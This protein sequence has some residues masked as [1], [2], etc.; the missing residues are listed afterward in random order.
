MFI[1]LI[2]IGDEILSGKR[3][4]KHLGHV[5]PMLAERGL[6]LSWCQIIGDDPNRITNT[7]KQAILSGD[8]VFCCGGIGA[9]PDDYT[10]QC[11]ANAAG[12]NLARH[13][14]ALSEIETRFGAEAYPNRVKMADLP[15]GCSIIPNPVN[16]VPGF[17]VGH[18]HFLP[19][20]P[21]MAWPM[22]EWVLDKHYQHLEPAEH[23]VEKLFI[24]P[25][26]KEADLLEVMESLVNS[27]PK[28]KLSSLPS[29][30]SGHI[31]AHIELGLKG[32]SA[33]VD[34]ASELLNQLLNARGQVFHPKR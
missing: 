5:I 11:A 21:E 18:V 33:V 9:T 6:S 2:I 19:G 13:P 10:R 1:G 23:E 34:A 14:Q 17:S 25:N 8:L 4:D 20:F 28:L 15:E 30:G 24:L 3:H 32:V 26:A 22:A 31:G 12:V 16:R 27:H 7:L 29:Y